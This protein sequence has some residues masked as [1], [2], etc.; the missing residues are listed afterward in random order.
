MTNQP[1]P[2]RRLLVPAGDVHPDQ[3]ELILAA[4]KIVMDS[5]AGTGSVR[6]TIHEG[7]IL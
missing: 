3:L 5:P 1:S 7:R 6:I 4:C 2:D